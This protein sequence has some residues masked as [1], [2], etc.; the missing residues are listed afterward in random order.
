MAAKKPAN[1]KELF[2]TEQPKE[3]A[4]KPEAAEP[5]ADLDKV[6]IKHLTIRLPKPVWKKLKALADEEE[7][8]LSEYL[9]EGLDRVF[10]ARGLPSSQEI[11]EKA[12]R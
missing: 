11:M 3:R 10:H 1:L 8:H 6:E 9:M 7:R 2:K 5:V 12:K 4:A